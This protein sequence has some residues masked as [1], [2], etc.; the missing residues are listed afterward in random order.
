[1]NRNIEKQIYTGK[2][3]YTVNNPIPDCP[4]FKW[5]FSGHLLHSVF[6]WSGFQMPGPKEIC[7][8]FKRSTPLDRFIN[9]MVKKRSLGPY[10]NLTFL[11]GG[12]S[13]FSRS[14]TGQN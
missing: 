6:E 14:K 1:M 5:P 2:N 9:N 7:S 3:I 12:P 11:N 13:C 8:V 4:V 10:K